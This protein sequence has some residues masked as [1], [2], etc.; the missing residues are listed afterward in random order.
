MV[1]TIY[2]RPQEE[3]EGDPEAIRWLA[4]IPEIPTAGR[5][6]TKADA[7]I[8]AQREALAT[9]AFQIGQ[10]QR[11]AEELMGIEFEISKEELPVEELSRRA[12]ATLAE[13]EQRAQTQPSQ[14]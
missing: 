11:M 5:G 9:L 8:D 2:Y 4:F 3:L 10:G 7:L 13:L 1:L 12:L 6:K 14:P